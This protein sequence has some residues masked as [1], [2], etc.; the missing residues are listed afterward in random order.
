M[1]LQETQVNEHHTEQENELVSSTETRLSLLCKTS[2]V[3]TL[4]LKQ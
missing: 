3:R 4:K 2:D 1:E